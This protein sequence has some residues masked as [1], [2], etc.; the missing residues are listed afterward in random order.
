MPTRV[1]KRLRDARGAC[2]E[3]TNFI[4]GVSLDT[5]LQDRAIR[6]IIERLLK[7]VGEA[8][9]HAVQEDN[10]LLLTIPESRVIIGMR[11][12]II[13]G[14]DDIKDEVVWDAATV[15]VPALQNQLDDILAKRGWE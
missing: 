4:N 9:N 5:Y 15:G 10:E 7:I 11:H 2:E 6:L 8:L 14:Y 1:A 12:R 3:I 13:H